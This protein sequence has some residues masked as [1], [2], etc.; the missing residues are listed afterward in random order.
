M[1]YINVTKNSKDMND[2]KSY[3]SPAQGNLEALKG[4]LESMESESQLIQNHQIQSNLLNTTLLFFT[5]L[6]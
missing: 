3:L 6:I 4:A 1:L 5:F 2:I